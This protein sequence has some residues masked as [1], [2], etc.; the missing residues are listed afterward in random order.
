MSVMTEE[1][2]DL[3]APVAIKRP[4]SGIA[5][6]PERLAWWRE[7]RG[8]SR[9]DLSDAVARLRL[10]DEYGE[11]LTVTRDAIAKI[12]NGERKPK[13]RTVRALCDA[14]SG[15]DDPC[16]PRDLM[17][18]GEPLPPHADAEERKLRLAHNKDL[19]AF[20]RA[21][22]IQYRNPV[23]GRV[24]YSVPLKDAFSAAVAGA[25][26]ESVAA[27]VAAAREPARAEAGS[28]ARPEPG[29]AGSEITLDDGIGQLDLSVRTH[30]TL[31]RM[32][33]RTI[34]D[35]TRTR[36]DELLGL[37][38]FGVTSLAEIRGKLGAAGFS[39][40]EPEPVPDDVQPEPVPEPV[41]DDVQSEPELEPAPDDV[42]H[43]TGG[44]AGTDSIANLRLSARPLNMLFRQG[45]GTIGE[46]ADLTPADLGDIPN[47]GAKS[48]REIRNA[49]GRAGFALAG[50]ENGSRDHGLLA[51]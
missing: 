31:I 26:D 41:P 12:E 42:Q 10:T 34:A 51:S 8:W 5:I 9:Q 35:L 17:P 7:T 48:V 4:A 50:G 19:R 21:H 37:R 38:G 33:I 11:P 49:L 25:G 16:T 32:G 44:L 45:V 36:A 14:L 30:N 47:L 22:G 6:D 27:L 13:A 28:P 24:Y 2:R 23:S 46:L 15:P 29:P 39:L 20:A 43:V 1:R 18:G 3:A 40:A